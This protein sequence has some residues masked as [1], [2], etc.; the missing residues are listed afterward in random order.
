MIKAKSQH[1]YVP[2]STP[3]EMML[4]MMPKASVVKTKFISPSGNKY[5]ITVV[6]LNKWLWRSS[7]ELFG[8]TLISEATLGK[9]IDEY[10]LAE[11]GLV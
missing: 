9:L 3:T 7:R 11:R 4:S 6:K 1:Y 5:P 10:E 2:S 8:C